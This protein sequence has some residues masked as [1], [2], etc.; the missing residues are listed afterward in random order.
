MLTQPEAYYDADTFARIKAA[1]DQQE[2]PVLIVD[3]KTF[4]EQLDHLMAC[5]PYANTYYAVKA[6]P[7]VAVLEILRDRGCNFDI[8]SRYE[9]DKVLSLGVGGDRVSF[10]NTIKKIKDIRYAYEKGVRLFASD[11]EADLRNIAE[12]APGSKVF[13]RILTEGSQTADWPLSRKFGCHVDMA[14]ELCIMARDLGLKPYGISFHV[15]SQQRDIGAWDSAIA[16]VK[17]IFER[18]KEE[19]NIE[20][21]M[22]NLGGGFPANYISRTNPLETYAEEITRFLKED[23][24]DELP[25]VI[26]EPGRSLAANAGILVSEVVLVSRKNRTGLDRWVY[27]DIGKFGGFVETMDEAIKYPLYVEKDGDT[28]EVIIAGPTCDS[29]DILYEQYKYELPLSLEAGDR[30]Y[31][32]S[33]GAYTTTYRAIEFNGFPPLKTIC[34]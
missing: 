6:N 5:F 15:G 24:G 33:T 10:G 26:L 14:I 12:A 11:S 27:T 21:K 22:V 17:W 8:A 1:A 18:L 3:T 29:A 13:V 30:M 4:G 2:T 20:M 23:F 19:E 7:E 32:F 16:K 9:L 28:E 25:D 34:I 31:W